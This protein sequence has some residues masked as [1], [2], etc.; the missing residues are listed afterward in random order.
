MFVFFVFLYKKFFIR[1]ICFSPQ[2]VSQIE[3]FICFHYY[4]HD[5]RNTLASKIEIK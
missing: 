5:L 1:F 4:E 2:R 3:I